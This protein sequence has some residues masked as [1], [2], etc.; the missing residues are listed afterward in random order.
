M[1]G[2][3]TLLLALTLL[4]L[5][6][7]DAASK[8][9]KLPDVEITYPID[10][11]TV[12]GVVDVKVQA[13][14]KGLEN[15]QLTIRTDGIGTTF[16]L[17]DCVVSKSTGVEQ[18]FEVMYCKYGLDTK[19]YGGKKVELTADV[20]DRNGHDRDTVAVLVSG[21]RAY[22]G[23]RS[24]KEYIP[25]KVPFQVYGLVRAKLMAAVAAYAPAQIHPRTVGDCYRPRR[26]ALPA[27]AAPN[28]VAV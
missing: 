27:H 1:K 20:K 24:P 18:V 22:N 5:F 19:P 3:E 4:A 16:Q 15:P 26:A 2:K 11:Q 10:G 14:G 23:E 7:V 17:K 6:P 12:E 28:A 9:P 21:D 13:K 25:D 8:D